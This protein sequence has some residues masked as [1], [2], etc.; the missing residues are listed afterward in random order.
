MVSSAKHIVRSLS[1]RI[2]VMVV[3]AIAVLLSIALLTMLRYARKAVK[4][5][6]IGNAEQTLEATVQHIDNVLL[7]VEQA[8]GNIY[9]DL[10]LHMNQPDRM[11]EYSRKLVETNR[12]IT[13]AAIVFEPY[14]YKEW[15]QYFMAYVHRDGP[16]SMTTVNMPIIQA[17]T[18][19]NVPYTEQVWYTTPMKT[20]KPC[21]INPLKDAMAEGEAII[22]FCIPIYSRENR[23]VG[24]L[25]ADVSLT[26][27]SDIVLAAKPSQNSYSTLLGSDGSYIVHPDSNKL[28]HMNVLDLRKQSGVDPTVNEAAQAMLAGESGYKRVRMN[29][30]DHYV[31]YKPFRRV[32]IPGRSM[33]ELGW[34]VGLIYPENDIFGDYNSLSYVVLGIALFG[35]LLLLLLCVAFTH[36]QFVPLTLLTKSAQ[37]IAEGHYDEPV[38]DTRQQDEVGRL[39]Q[40]FQAMQQALATNVGELERL[41]T[42]LQERGEVLAEAYEQA[43][44]ADRVKTAVL[45]NMTN[46]MIAPVSAICS[47]VETLCDQSQEMEVQKTE[48]VVDDIQRQGHAITELLSNLL[49][50]SQ[51]LGVRSG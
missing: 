29:G 23:P 41:T 50:V 4:D 14:Y 12:H 44:E 10:L 43:K 6:A 15:G 36:R 39:Q 32:A 17:E 37:R 7:S 28:F 45:H 5:E 21:W 19:G 20:G 3:F 1:V 13:G 18:F 8:T 42:T 49:E 24:V 35:L 47:S 34:S 11:F 25:A 2:S 26:L 48:Q 40:H 31:F 30:A 46:Q 27:L 22:T 51:E 16:S 9:W 33:E 38:P